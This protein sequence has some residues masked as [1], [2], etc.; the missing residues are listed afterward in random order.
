MYK[1]IIYTYIYIYENVENYI[2]IYG[3]I[4]NL[5]KD[6]THTENYLKIHKNINLY[7]HMQNIENCIK[8]IISKK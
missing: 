1:Q 3:H 4:A 5:S 8:Q 7:K 2:N 6:A